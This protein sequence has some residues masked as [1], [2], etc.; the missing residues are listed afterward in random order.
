M[1]IN[2]SPHDRFTGSLAPRISSARKR[3]NFTAIIRNV[4]NSTNFQCA[5]Q[6]IQ[7][8]VPMLWIIRWVG[9]FP[10]FVKEAKGAHFRCG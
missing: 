6:S 5:R 10:V 2:W 8:G 1:R 4:T 7:G 9:V 3:N